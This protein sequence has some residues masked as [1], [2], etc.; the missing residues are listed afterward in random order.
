MKD[1][2]CLAAKSMFQYRIA[3]TADSFRFLA[4][5]RMTGPFFALM[6]AL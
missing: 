2:G 4:I 6:E 5:T 1:G 3:G